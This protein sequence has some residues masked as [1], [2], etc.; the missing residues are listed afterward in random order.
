MEYSAGLSV[1]EGAQYEQPSGHL[2]EQLLLRRVRRLF[3]SPGRLF[4][5]HEVAC[6]HVICFGSAAAARAARTTSA[7]TLLK[8]LLVP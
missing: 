1:R 5:E 8:V 7:Q 4:I 6:P 2:G 3:P